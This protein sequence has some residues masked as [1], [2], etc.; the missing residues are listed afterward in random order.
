M[1][2]TASAS[3]DVQK[4]IQS[5]LH[6]HNPIVVSKSLDRPNVFFSVSE[7]KG[8]IVSVAYNTDLTLSSP[9]FILLY[10]IERLG[11]GSSSSRQSIA[12]CHP[13]DVDIYANEEHSM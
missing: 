8:Y 12:S 9:T 1:A 10:S 3:S 13:Q 7:I 11:W 2:L 6:L 5:S 4:L